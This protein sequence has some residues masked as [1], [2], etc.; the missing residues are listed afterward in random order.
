ML[1]SKNFIYLPEC[2]LY[3]LRDFLHKNREIEKESDN[4]SFWIIIAGLLFPPV[5]WAWLLL[6]ENAFSLSA[7][8]RI[9]TE[10]PL[11]FVVDLVPFVF[12]GIALFR[13]FKTG[14]NDLRISQ[15]IA[16]AE[17]VIRNYEKFMQDTGYALSPVIY[18]NNESRE[19]LQ[20][21]LDR[22]RKVRLE[23]KLQQKEIDEI[24]RSK[25]KIN[26][27]LAQ[28]AD[29]NSLSQDLLKEII[30]EAHAVQ[31]IFYVFNE[32]LQLFEST[33]VYAYGRNKS[34]HKKFK[35][36][37]G[38]LG[39]AVIEKD[40]IL[41]THIPEDYISITS[42]LLGETKPRCILIQPLLGN[43]EVQGVVEITSLQ[44]TFFEKDVRLLGE[45][46]KVIGQSLFSQKANRINKKLLEEAQ[47]LTLK[48]QNN[49]E[50]LKKNARDMLQAQEELEESNR[51]LA[52]KIT[53][54]E[55]A[56]ERVNALLENASEVITIYDVHG[57]VRYVSPS[58]KRILGFAPDEMVGTNRFERGDKKL[59]DC[60]LSL[61]KSES[62]DSIS[63]EYQ[64]TNKDGKKLWLETHGINLVDHP[65]I[66]GIIFNTLDITERKESEITKNLSGE[67][68]TLTENSPDM[69]VRMGAGGAFYY[70]N[71][72]T[73][74][75]LGIPLS[76]LINNNINTLQLEENIV[77]FLRLILNETKFMKKTLRKESDFLI[78]KTKRIVSVD[79][80]PELDD[81][82]N[83]A[84]ILLTVRDITERKK[85]EG[86]IEESNRSITESINYAHRIQSAIVPDNDLIKRYLPNSFVFFRPRDVVSGDLPWFYAGEDKTFI[87]AID[88]TGHGV[89]G[90][91]LSFIAYFSLN[92]IMTENENLETGQI[93]DKMHY[94][95]RKTLKQDSP[96]SKARDG[97]DIA[98]CKIDHKTKILEFSGAHSPLFYFRGQEL[99]RKRGDRKAIGGKPLRKGAVEKKFVTHKINIEKK[100]KFF[101]FTDGFPDQIGG[102]DGRK[103][104]A[105]KIKDKILENNF[106]MKE[107]YDFF[108]NELDTWKANY[109]QI[110][111]ILMIGVE[112]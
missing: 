55:Q 109:K 99:I 42:G 59:R 94:Q 83:V 30:D 79:S 105:G 102:E 60:F 3:M 9:H 89:P 65:A 104:Q 74:K 76:D 100:D 96:D 47:V 50:I 78:D 54:V 51:E 16:N 29:I 44:K 53:E 84:T 33:A 85:I 58:V 27:I 70:A 22:I 1:L 2:F 15:R 106:S 40:Y 71:P 19:L 86:A 39:Q 82:G 81:V 20:K 23:E 7:F 101:I 41:R 92:N 26:R 43:D 28:Y 91:L 80:I 10:N 97:M 107:Y 69:I 67:M 75:F 72:V 12:G 112:L 63:L 8:A 111:D 21:E 31:G 45:L 37:E 14:K 49:E 18:Q 73:E 66:N 88:C 93:L 108:A 98:I 35:I 77:T 57:Q 48:L 32:E 34:I 62:G 95:V 64:Y 36:G 90:T 56:R 6:R 5:S 61:V 24:A 13:I 4:T 25:A 46:G 87:A 38:L 68:K 11:L 103:Y 110:D 17:E 52:S